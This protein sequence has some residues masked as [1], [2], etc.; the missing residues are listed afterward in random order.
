MVGKGAVL[1]KHKID[2]VWHG[3]IHGHQKDFANYS[4]EGIK[5]HLI[6]CDCL[7]FSPRL[8]K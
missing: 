5:F 4:A 7:N 8:I 2:E 3:H 1:K 6:S